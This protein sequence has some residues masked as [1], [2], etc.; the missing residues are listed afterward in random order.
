ME[1]SY[2]EPLTWL[3]AVAAFLV[4]VSH[5]RIASAEKYALG[6]EASYFLPIQLISLGTFGVYLFFALSGCTLLISNYNK[7]NSVRDFGEFYFK[8]FMRIWPAFAVSLVIY[9]IFIEIFRYYYFFKKDFWIA[10]FL[11]EYSILNIFQYLSLTFNL[12][13][14]NGLFNRPYWSLPIEFQYYLL[15][16]FAILLMKQKHL[17]YIAPVLFGGVLYLLYREPIFSVDRNEVFKM[18]FSFFGGALLAI[19][20]QNTAF[21]MSIKLTL[22]LFSIAFLIVMLIKNDIIIIPENIP[23]LADKWNLYGVKALILLALALFTR[24]FEHSS[25]LLTFI[26]RYGEISYSIYLYHM[27]FIG[28]AVL[29]VNNYE[30]YG[31]IP[32]LFF[33]LSFSLIGSYLFSI[34]SYNFTE[35]PAISFAKRYQKSRQ[36]RGI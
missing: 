10:G 21:R 24:P 12:T 14:P 28:L 36:R 29:F 15:L 31:N 16:P 34:Y 4:V 35:K 8:R 18:G 17:T 20:F 22:P 3:R 5:C 25:K 7:V 32:K 1:K 27:M 6:D 30:I 11:R 19:I 33:I 9:I 13:G 26:H 23:F 2:L